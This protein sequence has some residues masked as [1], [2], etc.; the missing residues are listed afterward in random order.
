MMDNM[1]KDADTDKLFD[2]V[3]KNDNP[4]IEFKFI[5]SY[6]N[7]EGGVCSFCCGKNAKLYKSNRNHMFIPLCENCMRN[8][9]SLE[10]EK[11]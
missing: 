4:D 3:I 11:S 5:S 6:R 1:N 8:M 2:K 9:P 7:P 10:H